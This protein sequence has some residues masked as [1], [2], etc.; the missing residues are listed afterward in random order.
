[1]TNSYGIREEEQIVGDV[2]V[3]YLLFQ[4]HHVTRMMMLIETV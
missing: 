4:W 3:R 1:M 2:R